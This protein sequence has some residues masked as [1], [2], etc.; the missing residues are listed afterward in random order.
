MCYKK[1]G[2]VAGRKSTGEGVHPDGVSVWESLPTGFVF[3]RIEDYVG[4]EDPCGRESGDGDIGDMFQ[5]GAADRDFRGNGRRGAIEGV[6]EE[7]IDIG[8][9]NCA[10]Q[11]SRVKTGDATRRS[12]KSGRVN[13]KAPLPCDKHAPP[14]PL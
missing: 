11:A 9:D 6:R 2:G 10:R 14:S 13:V 7:D 3:E 1:T 5:Q 4:L 12:E 8:R